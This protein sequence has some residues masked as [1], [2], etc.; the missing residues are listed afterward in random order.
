MEPNVRSPLEWKPLHPAY[1][2][3]RGW[4]GTV[5]TTAC[6]N[7]YGGQGA[8]WWVPTLDLHPVSGHVATVEEAQAIAEEA[9]RGRG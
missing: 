2:D 3:L 1:P 6:V 9:W 7:R 8:Y 5:P 4:D